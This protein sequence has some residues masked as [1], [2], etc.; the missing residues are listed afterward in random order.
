MNSWDVYTRFWTFAVTHE[1]QLPEVLDIESEYN[2]KPRK[3][4][5]NEL[6][7]RTPQNLSENDPI[8]RSMQ[9]WK[10]QGWSHANQ[11]SLKGT[12][13]GGLNKLESL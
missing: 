5:L 1:L 8:N 10:G 12:F 11:I 6:K 2:L 9:S 3:Q 13:D 7:E 4:L